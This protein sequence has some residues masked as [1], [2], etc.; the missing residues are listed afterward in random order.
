MANKIRFGLSIAAGA[1]VGVTL[2]IAA[3]YFKAGMNWYGT[4][5]IVLSIVGVLVCWQIL[6]NRFTI[7][8]AA[9]SAAAFVTCVAFLVELTILRPAANFNPNLQYAILRFVFF[10]VHY[11]LDALQV[12]GFAMNVALFTVLPFFVGLFIAGFLSS[13][14]GIT[15]KRP[16]PRRWSRLATT[17]GIHWMAITAILVNLSH[18]YEW[19]RLPDPYEEWVMPSLTILILFV[20][21]FI[22]KAGLEMTMKGTPIDVRWHSVGLCALLICFFGT[23]LPGFIIF[24]ALFKP[25]W[26]FMAIPLGLAFAAGATMKKCAKQNRIGSLVAVEMVTAGLIVIESFVLMMLFSIGIQ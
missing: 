7:G 20:D 17:I 8:T 9:I 6:D 11:D 18:C 22:Q 3:V 14:I 19:E 4:F 23:T 13:N 5:V 12:I 16:M 26:L 2:L 25:L 1:C 15:G 10:D 24:A 21:V